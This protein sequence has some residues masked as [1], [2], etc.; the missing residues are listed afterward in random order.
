M[1]NAPEHFFP[2]CVRHS[3]RF[4]SSLAWFAIFARLLRAEIGVVADNYR[5][6]NSAPL[7]RQNPAYTSRTRLPKR[8][9]RFFARSFSESLPPSVMAPSK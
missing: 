4:S 2:K 7:L 8:R 3:A 9:V 5:F 6:R 1:C